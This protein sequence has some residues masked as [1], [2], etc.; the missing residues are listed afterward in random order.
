ML[1]KILEWIKRDVSQKDYNNPY[2]HSAFPNFTINSIY[3]AFR[4]NINL[5]TMA[6]IF[7]K[8]YCSFLY[9]IIARLIFGLAI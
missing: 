8:S 3:L 6:E 7:E 5:F 9:S 2:S 1:T 4:H